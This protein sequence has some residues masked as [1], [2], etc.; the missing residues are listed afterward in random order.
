MRLAAI[1][2]A[3]HGAERL[4]GKP[5]ADIGGVPMVVRVARIAKSAKGI[6]EVAVATDD[7]RIAAAVRADGFRAVMTSKLCKNGSERI[8]QAALEVPADG[9]LNVQGDEPLLD[10]RAIEA[11][12]ALVRQGH[13]MST[14][15]R[16]LAPGED[17]SN[18]SLCKVVLGDDGHAL[19][20]SRAE[21]PFQ[22]AP[23]V[24]LP[25]VHIGLYGFSKSFLQTFANL[26]E[27]AL[28][29]AEGLEQLRA[30]AHG[31]RIQVG[32]GFWTSIAVDTPEDL[33]RVRAAIAAQETTR[34]FS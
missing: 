1:I 3:R 14:L 25:L 5:L 33:E 27:T 22:R 15:A 34:R 29:R 13:A 4:P 16:P 9:Y 30:L 26:P 17:A 31:H 10:P 18:P 12:A 7:E 28:E 2:P 32:L 24:V 23:G 8:A 20:F 19:Y 21:V 11:L 6:D